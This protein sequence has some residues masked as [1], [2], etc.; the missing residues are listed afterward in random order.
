MFLGAD[1]IVISIVGLITATISWIA[2]RRIFKR[3]PVGKPSFEQL[4]GLLRE[5]WRYWALAVIVFF[6]STFQIP[7]IA[8]LLGTREAGIFRS[9]FLMAA[10][11]EL[12]F[13]SINSLLLARLVIW[14]KQG[15][16]TMW[17]QQ[18]R[19]LLI[20]LGIGGPLTLVLYFF[21][22]FLY[23]VLLGKDFAEGVTI[24]QILV[25]GR[26]VVFIGQ[27]YAWGLAAVG[28][29]THFVLASL[30]GAVSSVALNLFLIPRYG[31][32]AAACIAVFAEL[33]VHGY[34]FGVLRIHVT[35]EI[36][37]LV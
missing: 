5:S 37:T 3:W 27:I 13:N 28:L 4:R 17:K 21:A 33:L 24:F 1:L 22:P 18:T 9:A 16:H 11:V 23:Q 15:L 30:L 32:I 2:Y 10:G 14:K 29:D 6:Y 20:F 7:L 26:L 34:S 19:L 35:R 36:E 12:L 31:L 25:I 8:G